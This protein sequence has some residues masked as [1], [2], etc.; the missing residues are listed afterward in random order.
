MALEEGL[1]Y[2][3]PLR[4][5]A[6]GYWEANSLDYYVHGYF[7]RCIGLDQRHRLTTREEKQIVEYEMGVEDAD[8]DIAALEDL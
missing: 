2:E 7:D 3:H 1:P 4:V 5:R 8:G 6:K